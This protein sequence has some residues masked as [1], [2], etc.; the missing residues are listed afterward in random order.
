MCGQFYIEEFWIFDELNSGH[1]LLSLVGYFGDHEF[2]SNCQFLRPQ[3]GFGQIQ[4]KRLRGE[5]M[6]LMLKYWVIKWGRMLGMEEE[7]G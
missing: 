3:E 2:C 1:S 6:N 5:L 4:D 7:L